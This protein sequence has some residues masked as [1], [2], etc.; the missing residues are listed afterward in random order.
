[1]IFCSVLAFKFLSSEILGE[2]QLLRF[3]IGMFTY[4]VFLW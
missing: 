1:L 4:K 2:Y 3:G